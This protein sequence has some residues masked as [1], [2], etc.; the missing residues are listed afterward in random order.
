MKPSTRDFQ[1]PSR[2][3]PA[4]ALR[5]R[6]QEGRKLEAATKTKRQ[7][8]LVITIAVCGSE[9]CDKKTYGLAE[10]VGALIAGAGARLIC[11]GLSG[12]MEAAAKGARNAGGMT[13]GILPGPDTRAGNKYL[14]LVIATGAGFTRNLA[15]VSS[16]DG[17]VAI[18]GRFG[19]LSEIAY[20]LNAKKPVALLNS[21][22]LKH[23]AMQE[24]ACRQFSRPEGA[25]AWLVKT[26]RELTA[27]HS[28][29]SRQP[30]R[31]TAR[32]RRAG[33]GG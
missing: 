11:G 16:C 29:G 4:L 25:I 8:G 6:M 14:D 5:P 7:G 24:V 9:K 2:P 12:V 15:I 23:N 28:Y 20:A 22:A 30:G 32:Q 26:I 21:W 27:G 18:G 1:C 31:A 33:C 3:P 17:V 13:I 10:S 19:T